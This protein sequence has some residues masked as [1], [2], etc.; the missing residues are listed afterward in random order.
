MRMVAQGKYKLLL[1]GTLVTVS[2]LNLFLP[3]TV[4]GQ[5]STS[6]S[7]ERK[8][9]SLVEEATKLYNLYNQGNYQERIPSFKTPLLF[10][11]FRQAALGNKH[12][13]Y[14][15]DLDTRALLY[16]SQGRYS[17]AEPLFRQALDITKEQLGPDHPSVASRLNNLAALYWSLGK[18]NSTLT[19]LQQGLAIEESNLE[20]NL[21]AGSEAQKQAYLLTLD[22]SNQA[23]ISLHLQDAPHSSKA[24][25]L[26]FTT[27]AQRKGRLLDFLSHNKQLLRRNLD[28]KS[29]QLLDD[30]NGAKSQLANLYHYPPSQITP[31]YHQTIEQ[32]H[33]QIRTLEAQLSR[34]S[35][36]YRQASQPITIKTIQQQLP[37]HTALVEFVQYQPYNPKQQ[38]WD[39][40]RYAVYLLHSQGSPVGRDLGTVAE[41][42]TTL[43]LLKLSLQ[44]P[45]TPP[46]QL[47]NVTH[48][49]Y[50]LLMEPIRSHL[51]KTRQILIAPDQELNT[52]PFEAL[53]DQN[54]EYLVQN[55]HITYLT[56]SRDLVRI[57]QD[58]DSETP[59]LLLGNP[60]FTQAL[61]SPVASNN[62]NQTNSERALRWSDISQWSFSPIPQTETEVKTLGKLLGVK[63]LIQE[64]ATEAVVKQT[65][66]PQILHIA[67]HGFF[68][69]SNNDR[70]SQLLRSGLVLAG[71]QNPEQYQNRRM[72]DGILTALE[73]TGLNLRGTE[74]VVLS[75]CETGQGEVSRGDGL[76]GL[77][78][79]LVIAGAETQVIS[80]WRVD[81]NS[82]KELMIA[83][84]QRLEQGQGRSEALRQ[85]QLAV[86]E[87]TLEN[88]SQKKYQHPYYWAGFIASGNWLPMSEKE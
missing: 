32:F 50:Q 36:L 6:A 25:Q 45:K 83:Y 2:S 33:Q 3:T 18:I 65:Q 60:N 63:P 29:Q 26:A 79:A 23:P 66:S 8:I 54:Q 16:E 82:T 1:L 43:K 39:E 20:Y 40:P 61:A 80:L 68:R 47:Q 22:W 59:P 38:S 19:Y 34:H 7:T 58:Y 81:D 88:M 49:V 41:I 75:A 85:T 13:H 87:G 17:E 37:A 77:R 4:T 51:G 64:Q 21:P 44:D 56:S 76:Y 73:V 71:F 52:I 24:A 48:E 67:T 78:R 84:Y 31:D 46:E 42:E 70:T 53:V 5:I 11:F 28:P 30:L 9:S 15:I 72:E 35:S 27:I 62:I 74:L 10:L 12:L 86:L 55:Y 69:S 14:A 57:A